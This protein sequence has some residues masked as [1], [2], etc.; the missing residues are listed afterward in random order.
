MTA[1][2][3]PSLESAA[4]NTSAMLAQLSYGRCCN[5]PAFFDDFYDYFMSM[6]PQI[7]E[8]FVRT[9]FVK[10]KALLRQALTYVIMLSMGSA[11]AEEHLKKLGQSHG[12]RGLN[13]APQLYTMMVEALIHAIRKHDKK[14]TPELDGAW[15]GVMNKAIQVIHAEY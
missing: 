14:F 6:S 10:Q 7:K 11:V 12:S 2:P 4:G 1:S 3:M 15:R 9:D 5:S 13:I 8:Y